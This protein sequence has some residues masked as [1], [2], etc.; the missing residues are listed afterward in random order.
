MCRKYGLIHH[1]NVKELPAG[2]QGSNTGIS[3]SNTKEILSEI[4]SSQ[5]INVSSDSKK[6]KAHTSMIRS[7]F[8]CSGHA[9]K[10]TLKSD[11]NPS[12]S[13]KKKSNS[14]DSFLNSNSN[15]ESKPSSLCSSNLVLPEKGVSDLENEENEEFIVKRQK[16]INL[17]M[18]M[19]ENQEKDN[20]NKSKE[21]V[22]KAYSADLIVKNEQVNLEKKRRGRRKVLK[23]VTSCDKKGYLVTKNE[24][25]WESF[26][27]D[28]IPAPTKTKFDTESKEGSEKNKP[29]TSETKITLFFSKK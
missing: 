14:M 6:K 9:A 10:S 4:N 12:K 15:A 29:K 5:T 3:S 2:F 25:V 18:E 23:K 7:F 21:S 17:L 13:I 20:A 1:V 16:E 22:S 19:M 11:K 24:F 28:E 27:E 8:D 26:S